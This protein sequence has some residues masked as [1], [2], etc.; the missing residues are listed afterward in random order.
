MGVADCKAQ[1][2]GEAAPM[3]VADFQ[4]SQAAKPLQSPTA[5]GLSWSLA[6]PMGVADCK[7]QPS[8]EAASI[9]YGD[10]TKLELSRAHG[11]GK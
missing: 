3:G 5:I 10:W 9:A 8:G 11:S 2:S 7:A 6:A 1:P 4:V